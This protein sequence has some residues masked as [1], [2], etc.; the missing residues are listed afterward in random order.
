[1]KKMV[2]IHVVL[3][4]LAAVITAAAAGA[5][6]SSTPVLNTLE[7]QTLIASAEPADHARLSAH[8]AALADRHV[9]DATRHTAMAQAYAGNR[10]PGLTTGMQAHCKRL[11]DLAT[12]SATTLREL[13]SFHEQLAAGAPATAP[14]DAG[15]FEEGRGARTPTSQELSALAAKAST[16]ADHRALEEYFL[17][18][19]KAYTTDA[20]QQVAL[21]HAYRGTRIATATAE[22]DHLAALSRDAAKEANAAADMHERL[23]GTAR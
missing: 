10:A 11:A 23:A 3:V 6:T 8:F 18:L 5:Q 17:T 13:A 16:P 20:D 4:S 12:Q 22:H 19:A 2:R 21:A 14:R 7:L 9:A 15:R 1:M